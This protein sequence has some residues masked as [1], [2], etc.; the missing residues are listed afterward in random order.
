VVS[1]LLPPRAHTT[2]TALDIS[3]SPCRGIGANNYFSEVLTDVNM[4][5]SVVPRPF[6]TAMMARLMPHAIKAYSIAVAAD[7]SA[8]NRKNNFFIPHLL[9]EQH[10][11]STGSPRWNLNLKG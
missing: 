4:V 5:L 9:A 8:K 2:K 7:W 11:I 10:R 3:R 1:R 6:T